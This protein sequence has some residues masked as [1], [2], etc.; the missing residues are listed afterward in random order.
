MSKHG[1][2]IKHPKKFSA[3]QVNLSSNLPMTARYTDPNTIGSWGI[4]V[5]KEPIVEDSKCTKTVDNYWV[6]NHE[7]NT[8]IKYSYK[9]ETLLTIS[10]VSGGTAGFGPTAV[11]VNKNEDCFYG[12]EVIT[13]TTDGTIQYY[14]PDVNATTTVIYKY[15]S[16]N[17][18]AEYT[19]ADVYKCNLYVAN[20]LTG[21]VE[22]YSSPNINLKFKFA[23]TE[24]LAQGYYAYNVAVHKGKIYV[25]YVLKD[26]SGGVTGSTGSTGSNPCARSGYISEFCPDGSFVRRIII[27]K[28]LN[29]PWGMVFDDCD[30]VIYV[31]NFLD[32]M[33][34]VFNL[35]DGCYVGT[36]KQCRCD[37]LVINGL[38]GLA[39]A[40]CGL[41]FAAGTVDFGLVGLLTFD[42]CK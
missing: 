28:Y 42:C 23:D 1:Q 32:G 25:A 7:S 40:K 19:G 17:M 21:Y 33:I 26:G 16:I 8:L 3:T 10:T 37:E 18:P 20:F 22:V 27:S 35:C 41:A 6:A 5:V 29:G 13:V 30:D 39:W 24:L 15:P 36:V 14:L 11:V 34:H 9:G 38:H 2:K 12:A 4:A 31:G